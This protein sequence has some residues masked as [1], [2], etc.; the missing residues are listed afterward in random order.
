MNTENSQP[1]EQKPKEEVNKPAEV[2]GPTEP[3]RETHY[4]PKHGDKS[5]EYKPYEFQPNAFKWR[6]RLSSPVFH[7]IST[8]VLGLA[9]IVLVWYVIVQTNIASDMAKSSR[10]QATEMQEQSTLMRE[11]I[12]ASNNQIKETLEIG[13]RQAEVA[14]K[15]LGASAA[16]ISCQGIEHINIMS[17]NSEFQV[18]PIL[19]NSGNTPAFKF[20]VKTS[21]SPELPEYLHRFMATEDTIQI[22]ETDVM[23]GANKE[24]RTAR[25][26]FISQELYDAIQ[27]D[28]LFLTA[29]ITFAYLDVWGISHRKEFKFTYAPHPSMG[30]P[31]F[32][33]YV[34]P[35]TRK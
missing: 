15:S 28:K 34:P 5:Q 32:V 12:D 27:S 24:F 29:R 8:A 35:K 10:E 1:E 17:P 26:I 31:Q 13:R 25:G 14:E 2:G 22:P 3:S 30:S 20:A 23:V 7:S 21:L 33:S 9:N 19:F 11:S 4:N 16:F 18:V 6:K